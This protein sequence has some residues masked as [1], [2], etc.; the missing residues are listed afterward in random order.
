MVPSQPAAAQQQHKGERHDR[1]YAPACLKLLAIA[2]PTF[3]WSQF[4]GEGR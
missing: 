1:H 2:D 3:V 4:D